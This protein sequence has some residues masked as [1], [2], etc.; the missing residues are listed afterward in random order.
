MEFLLP[1]LS[2]FSQQGGGGAET[3]SGVGQFTCKDL[4]RLNMSNDFL[5]KKSQ[6]RG[7][8]GGGL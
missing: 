2:I 5:G 8:S 6:R 3:G 7:L 4:N 1:W